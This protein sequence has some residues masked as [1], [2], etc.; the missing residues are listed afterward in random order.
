MKS[1]QVVERYFEESRIVVTLGDRVRANV[2]AI[3][4]HK[5]YKKL[6]LSHW[7]MVKEVKENE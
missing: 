1:Y 3:E 6:G 4:L 7:F 5:T 2:I